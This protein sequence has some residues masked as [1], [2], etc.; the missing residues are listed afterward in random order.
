MKEITLFKIPFKGEI[1]NCGDFYVFR[2]ALSENTY[3]LLAHGTPKGNIIINNKEVSLGQALYL[4]YGDIIP[5]GVKNIFTLSCYGGLQHPVTIGS[6]TI[7]S[8]H[9]ISDKIGV[10][11]GSDF[12]AYENA[13]KLKK[14]Q[15][16]VL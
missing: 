1:T 8:C 11:I 6:V 4:L 10:Y 2:S 15:I 7:Q 3:Y 14:H 13:K 12:V 16:K 9:K 5:E